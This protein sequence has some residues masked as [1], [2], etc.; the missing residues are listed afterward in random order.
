MKKLYF[1]LLI[2]I[3]GCFC[4]LYAQGLSLNSDGSNPDPSAILDLKSDNKGFLSPRM[5]QAQREAIGSPATGLMVYQTNAD[6]GFWYYNGAAWT[7]LATRE[8]V[9]SGSMITLSQR[10]DATMSGLGFQY[11]GNMPFNNEA[12]AWELISNTNTPAVRRRHTAIWTGSTMIIWGGHDGSGPLNSGAIYS[13]DTDTWTTI[14]SVNAPSARYSHS[15]IWTGSKM[16]IWGGLGSGNSQKNDGAIYDPLTDSWT[17]TS[18][19]NV[20]AVRYDH[21]AIWTGTE[22]IIWGGNYNFAIMYSDGGRFNPETNSWTSMTNTNA[23]P[24]R[25]SHTGIWTGNKMIVWGGY[26]THT[27]GIYDPGTDSWTSMSTSNGPSNR[28]F[29]SF[30]WTG[31]DLII[32]GG[33]PLG[34]PLGEGKSYNLATDTWSNIASATT[35]GVNFL[36]FHST[37]W[38]GEKMIVWGGEDM[39]SST[40]YGIIYD[41]GTDTWEQLPGTDSPLAARVFHSAVWTG[42]EMIV[43]GGDDSGTYYPD[44]ASFNELLNID[45]FY[46]YI[47]L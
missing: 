35:V 25:F 20:P 30:V 33:Y 13:P 14:S 5:T 47:K 44:G 1:F 19:T 28:Y 4:S 45:T 27:G 26:N 3:T 12:D 36:R 39:G 9:K 29:H 17:T 41:P 24:A 15:A 23:P 46:I 31:T 8:T 16:I 37:I 10:D 6:S 40:N 43:W 21:S 34:G 32:W 42:K 2:G 18:M 22:M 38:T 7:Q 11:L